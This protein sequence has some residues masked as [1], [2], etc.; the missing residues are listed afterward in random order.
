MQQ[1]LKIIP[2]QQGLTTSLKK[3]TVLRQQ[4]KVEVI[5]SLIWLLKRIAILYQ[6]PGFGD[7]NA[8]EL[9]DWILER[10]PNELGGTVFRA[11]KN[12]PVITNR[13]NEQESQWRLS[14][15]TVARWIT[16]EIEKTAIELEI[17]AA[18]YL[19]NKGP[20]TEEEMMPLSKDTEKLI[21]H[22][23]NELKQP[24]AYRRSRLKINYSI[25]EEC[26][27]CHGVKDKRENENIIVISECDYCEGKGAIGIVE[28]KAETEGEAKREYEARF[29]V[30]LR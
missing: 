8:L 12:P 11:L 10:Y 2:S 21:A 9:A 1:L 17:E 27:K 22:F 6:I 26:P 15:D 18:R 25:G 29:N 3:D 30:K 14:P 28:I 13:H 4:D 20:L 5:K 24:P 16:I 7:E 19:E 23:A